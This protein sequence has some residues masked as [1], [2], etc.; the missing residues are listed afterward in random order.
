MFA[1]SWAM[2][3]HRIQSS[4]VWLTNVKVSYERLARRTHFIWEKLR[5]PTSQITDLRSALGLPSA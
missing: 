5:D 2:V 4:L 1:I 3:L